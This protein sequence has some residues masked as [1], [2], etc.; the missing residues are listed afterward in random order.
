M[1]LTAAVYSATNAQLTN[2]AA[3]DILSCPI[4]FSIVFTCINEIQMIGLLEM[5][6]FFFL[7]FLISIEVIELSIIGHIFCYLQ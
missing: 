4:K 7:D 3:G 1:L 2:H 6:V 5:S